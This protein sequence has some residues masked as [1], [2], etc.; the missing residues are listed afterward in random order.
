[1]QRAYK[2]TVFKVHR[3]VIMPPKPHRMLHL[4]TTTGTLFLK[5]AT[6]F[7]KHTELSLNVH[8]CVMM[9][10]Y[11]NHSSQQTT[12]LNLH[13]FC[14]CISGKFNTPTNLRVILYELCCNYHVITVLSEFTCFAG[15]VCLLWP[16]LL[17][18]LM[19]SIVAHSEYI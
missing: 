13:M 6:L 11:G 19:T 3:T 4:P 7:S 16:P 9:Y 5:D 14:H 2:P 12:P 15:F 1:M 17:L 8:L 18:W 10:L